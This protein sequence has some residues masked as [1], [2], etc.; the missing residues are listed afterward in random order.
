MLLAWYGVL[1]LLDVGAIFGGVRYLRHT[2][3]GLYQLT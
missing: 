1:T 3:Q 2:Q